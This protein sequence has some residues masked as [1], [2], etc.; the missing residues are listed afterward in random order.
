MSRKLSAIV[1]VLSVAIA[2][3][4]SGCGGP[5]ASLSLKFSPDATASYKATTE[6][7]KDFRFD[8]PNLG[9]LREEQTKTVIEMTY[10][11]TID[12]VDEAGNAMATIT[13]N[14]LMI[15]MVNKNEP[16]FAFD[17]KNESDKTNPMAKL[18][19]QSY[20]IQISPVGQ[21]TVLDAAQARNAVKQGFEAKVAKGIL[22][23]KAISERHQIP[24]LPQDQA[25]TLAVGD[26]W[27]EQVP[28]PPGLLAPKNYNKNYTLSKI[29]GTTA[30]VDMVAAESTQ[31]ADGIQASGGGMGMF[32]KMFDNTDE[33]TGSLKLDT[34]AGTIQSFQEQLVSTYIAQE[35]P[36]NGDPQKG[37]DTLTMRFTNIIKMEKVN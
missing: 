5:A 28:S 20:K 30:T 14:D 29:E 32:A 15:D 2:L 31:A 8:Q 35:M 23:D 6:V 21:V 10:A 1:M 9:K 27:T 17:S 12:S 34:A 3:T 36:E 19:G 7:I 11:Q 24:G 33:Y 25:Q 18:I 13:I 16:K 26:T 22:E 37:P 4:L